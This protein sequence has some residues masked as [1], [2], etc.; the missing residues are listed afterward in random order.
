[1]RSNERHTQ[2]TTFNRS[3]K[4]PG[5][6]TSTTKGES[7]QKKE[8]SALYRNY[9]HEKQNQKCIKNYFS[10]KQN[11]TSQQPRQVPKKK[12][13][14]DPN[15]ELKNKSALIIQRCYR[16]SKN[17]E[18]KFLILINFRQKENLKKQDVF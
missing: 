3:K 18:V 14:S 16:N 11:K 1:M 2:S 12:G 8:K 10:V 15:F 13:K 6:V 5:N 17:K 9:F 4:V 7:K